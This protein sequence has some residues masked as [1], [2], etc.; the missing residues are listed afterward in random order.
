MKNRNKFV[1]KIKLG[2]R[3]RSMGLLKTTLLALAMV[4]FS[5]G[6]SAAGNSLS[7]DGTG[8]YVSF[9]EQDTFDL[10]GDFTIESWIYLNNTSSA[11]TI[12][13]KR[14]QGAANPNTN[15]SLRVD[16]GGQ[17]RFFWYNSTGALVDMSESGSSVTALSWQHIAATYDTSTNVAK[18]YVDGT[19]VSTKTA[20]SDPPTNN[21][22]FTIGASINAGNPA[23]FFNGYIDELR[24]S[25]TIRYS[26]SFTAPSLPFV[27]DSLT[28]AL[29]HFD[30]SAGLT[31]V[32]NF[33]SA[34]L[35]HDGVLQGN[36]T[37]STTAPS[38]SNWADN[39]MSFDG[40]DDFFD[41]GDNNNLDITGNLTVEAWVKAGAVTGITTITAKWDTA[42]VDERSYRLFL[43][44]GTPVFA[45][46]SNGTGETYVYSSSNVSTSTWNHIAGVYDGSNIYIFVNGTL[47]GTVAYSSGI[48]SG[49]ANFTVGA[50]NSDLY[51]TGDVDELR[52]SNS[53]RYTSSFTPPAENF[54][55][56]ANTA[57][58]VH[59]SHSDYQTV[60]IDASG[61]NLNLISNNGAAFISANYFDVSLSAGANNPG[62]TN[63]SSG[64]TDIPMLQFTIDASGAEEDISFTSVSVSASGTADDATDVTSVDLYR[65][66]NGNGLLDDGIDVFLASAAGYSSNDGDATISL[67][68]TISSGTSEDYLVAYSL[69]GTASN[70]ETFVAS[71][72]P[73]SITLTGVTSSGAYTANGTTVSGGVKTI[74]SS[75]YVTLSEGNDNP[76]NQNVNTSATDLVLLQMKVSATSASNVTVD[77]VLFLGTTGGSFDLNNISALNLYSDVNENGAFDSGVDTLISGPVIFRA[78]DYAGFR[79]LSHLVSAGT[80]QLW[81]VTADF[82]GETASNSIQ[83][84]LDA[85]ADFNIASGTVTGASVNGP[86]YTVSPTGSLNLTEGISNPGNTNEADDA[87]DV[88]VLQF[89]LSA[90]ATEAID[91]TRIEFSAS[92]TGNDAGDLTAYLYNDVND[93]GIYENGTDIQIGG[94]STYQTDDGITYWNLSLSAER[95]LAN[96]SKS[97]LLVYDFDGSAS[98][99]ETFR[100][101]ITNSGIEATGVTSTNSVT[102]LGSTVQGGI[103]TI[104]SS[105]S[106]TLS[107]NSLPAASNVA[108]NTANAA[109]YQFRLSA[110]STENIQV[111]SVTFE[112]IGTA[113]E[114][115]DI[116]SAG[117]NLYKDVNSNGQYD[118]GSDQFIGNGIR[119]GGSEISLDGSGD[120]L[121]LDVSQQYVGGNT[122]EGITIETWFRLDPSATNTEHIIASLD[123]S[124]FWR[125]SIATN[126]RPYFSTTNAAGTI[127]DLYGTTSLIANGTWYH[128][129]AVYEPSTGEKRIYI[130]GTLDASV[131]A[132]T[133]GT[134][135]GH[136]GVTRYPFIGT[137][138]EADTYDGTQGPTS[139]FHG[140]IDEFRIS[141][142]VRYTSDFTAPTTE[143]SPDANTVV[144]YH[145]N[146]GSG[147][148]INNASIAYYSVGDAELR[149]NSTFVQSTKISNSSIR[150]TTPNQ[151]IAAGGSVDWLLAYDVNS[152]P[153]NGETFRARITDLYGVDAS[154][155]SS[156][157]NIAPSASFPLNGNT[158]TVSNVGAIS[159]QVGSNTPSA[160]EIPNNTQSKAMLQMQVTAANIED[161]AIQSFTFKASGSGD[162]AADLDSVTVAKDL[163]DNGTYDDGVDE[164]ISTS[165]GTYA[166]NN[167]TTTINVVD[168]LTKNTSQNYLA[169]YYFDAT[170]TASDDETFSVEISTNT[171]I[172]ATGVTSST[173]PN[174]SGAPVTGQTMTINNAPK[175][176]LSP[177]SF[178]PGDENIS[179]TA[180]NVAMI[181]FN[182]AASQKETIKL[183]SIKFID[184]G[185][186]DVNT[187]LNTGDVRLYRDINNNGTLETGTD[188][189][190]GA[191]G[192]YIT[193]DPGNALSVDGT[194]DYA[195]FADD[196]NLDVTGA[197]TIEAW[198]YPSEGAT[199]TYTVLAKRDFGVEGTPTN[200]AL[201]VDNY[202][203]RFFFYSPDGSL[204]DCF[205]T[206]GDAIA[207]HTPIYP[208][209]WYHVAGVYDATDNEMRLYV[210]G[211]LVAQTT[212]ITNGPIPNDKPLDIGRRYNSGTPDSYFAGIIEEIRLSDTERYSGTSFTTP[213]T[214]FSTDANTRLL[215]HFDE[216]TGSTSIADSSGNGLTGTL[217]NGASIVTSNAPLFGG[218]TIPLSNKTITAGSSQNWLLVYDYNGNAIDADT[219][220]SRL[221]R[222]ADIT[223]VGNVSAAVADLSGLPVTG[224]KKTI[225][226]TGS[227]TVTEGTNNPAASSIANDAANVSMLQF[228]LSAS[229]VE[230]IDISSITFKA[231]GTGDDL[232][233]IKVNTIKLY[234]DENSDGLYSDGTDVFIGQG[235]SFSADNGTISISAAGFTL[236]ANTSSDYILIMSFDSTATPGETFSVQI[237][238]NVAI[239]ATG[240]TS[241]NSI[242]PPSVNFPIYG[243]N[244]TISDV[245][246]I[247]MSVGSNS[248]ANGDI[249][250]SSSTVEMMQIQLA[251]SSSENIK[252]GKLILKTNGT[253][254]DVTDLSEIYLYD[255]LNNNG[256][257]DTGVD[258]LITSNGG[259]FG[260][261]NGTL[262]FTFA[263]SIL[264]AASTTQ[265]WLVVYDFS[266]NGSNDDTFYPTIELSSYIGA[267]GVTSKLSVSVNG[268]F[269]LTGATKTIND[270]GS[271]TLG[272][273]PNSPAATNEAP[274]AVNVEMLQLSVG[275]SQTEA[276]A[277]DSLTLKA[278]G[279]I[280]DL[281][282]VVNVRLYK[283][284]NNNGALDLTIDTQLDT[285]RQFNANNGTVIFPTVNDTIAANGSENWLVIYDLDGNPSPGETFYVR[286]DVNANL[287]G[288]GETSAQA[289]SVSG[290]PINGNTKT[291]T[292]KGNL[293]LATGANNPGNSNETSDATNV[294]MIQFSLAASS[295]EN[296]K[297]N[298]LTFKHSGTLD[299]STDIATN[300][301]ELYEDDGDG[302]FND[303]N[304]IFVGSA[305]SYVNNGLDLDGTADY[306]ALRANS[307]SIG[308]TGSGGITVEA[309]VKL[310]ASAGTG[311]Y[312]LISLDRSDYWRLSIDNNKILWATAAIDGGTVIDDMY[313]GSNVSKGTWIHVAA[314][315]DPATGTKKI[316]YNGTLDGTSTPYSASTTLG[317]GS[318][319]YAFIGVG[320]EASSYNGPTGPV[321]YFFGEIDE[322]RIS[323]NVRYSSNFTPSSTPFIADANTSAL[324]QFDE[325]SGS[326]TKNVINGESNDFVGNTAFKSNTQIDPIYVTINTTGQVVPKSTTKKYLLIYDFTGTATNGETINASINKTFISA[327]GSTSGASISASG[328]QVTGGTK[329]ITNVGSISLSAGANNPDAS[330]E[331]ASTSNLVMMQLQLTT[332]SAETLAVSKF[333]VNGSGTADESTDITNLQLYRDEN[334]NGVFDSGVD[335]QI[336][337]SAT[338]SG[339]DGKATWNLSPADTL[340]AGTTTNWLVIYNLAGSASNG[341][342]IKASVQLA[343]NITVTGVES[344]QS[345][346]A[347]G[348]PVNGGVKT[349]TNIGQ[350]S[351]SL[352]TENPAANSYSVDAS[353]IVV[354][355]FSFDANSVEDIRID[356]LRFDPQGTLNHLAGITNARLYLDAV[357]NGQFDAVGDVLVADSSF[358][359]SLSTLTFAVGD[360]LLADQ[361][362]HYI[363]VYDLAGSASDSQTFRLNAASNNYFDATGLGG[364]DHAATVIGAPLTTNY[365]TLTAAGALDVVA[366]SANPGS[367]NEP[368]DA[369]GIAMLQ[370]RLTAS[371][372]ENINVTT[373]RINGVGTGDDAIDISQIG[374]YEDVNGNG[375]YDINTDQTIA[376]SSTFATND[377]YLTISTPGQV[378]TKG[379]SQN[380]LILY[381]FSGSASYGE[382][383]RTRLLEPGDVT[384]SGVTS[385]QS[386]TPTMSAIVGGLKTMSTTGNLTLAAGSSNPINGTINAGESGV[387]ILQLRLTASSAESLLVASAKFKASGT[388]NDQTDIS[389]VTLYNDLNDNGLF[390]SGV[391]TLLA[392]SGT[393]SADDTVITF[394]FADSVI[395]NAGETQNWLLAYDFNSG[396]SNNNTYKASIELASYINVTGAVSRQSLTPSGSFAVN[397]ATKSIVSVGILTINPGS[398]N[399]GDSYEAAGATNIEM[400]AINMSVSAAESLRVDQLTATAL[401]TINDV[402]DISS[403]RLYRD[404]NA[405][406]TLDL[407]VDTQL[408]T[409]HIYNGDN[410]TLVFA[411]NDTLIP[412]S[413]TDYLMVY[414]LSGSASADE[415]FNA[416]VDIGGYTVTGLESSQSATV[417]GE[418]ITSGK[419]TITSVGGLSLTAGTSNP[420]SSNEAN[421]ATD[422]EVLQFKL[423]A[424]SVENIN[425]SSVTFR[426]SGT[427]NPNTGITANHIDLYNDNGNGIYEP[428]TDVFVGNGTQYANYGLSFDGTGDYVALDAE[429]SS[430]GGGTSGGITIEAWFKLDASA[431]N[432]EHIIA[433]M[434]R[435]DYWRLSVY[436]N[437]QPYFSTASSTG[438]ID[439]L[440]GSTG[441]ISNGTWY[442]IAAV[443]DP[444]TGAK[445]IYINGQLDA[446]NSP[447]APSTNLGT[448]AD[449]YAFIGTG[450]ESPTFNGPTGPDEWFHGEID[451][452]RI[453][454]SVRYSSNFTPS[455]SPF[456]VDANTMAL[457]HMDES[458]GSTIKNSASSSGAGD[459]TLIGNTTFL[460][461]TTMDGNYI[462]IATSGQVVP[463][464]QSKTWLLVYDLAGTSTDGKTFIANIASSGIVAS[465]ATS[466]QNITATG[467]NVA[468]GT[469]TM[470]ST[471]SLTLSAGLNN[472]EPGTI[473]TDGSGIVMMQMQLQTSNN[474]PLEV[475][476]FKVKGS[477]TGIEN[478]DVDSVYLYRD[479]NSNGT[480]DTGVDTKLYNQGKVFSADNEVITWSFASPIVLSA[481]ATENWIVVYDYKGT[482]SNGETFQSRFELASYITATGQL[483]S[484]SITPS[485]P[486]PTPIT[487]NIQTISNIGNLQ[488]SLGTNNPS[489]SGFATDAQDV[490]VFQ[491]KISASSAEDIQV[492]TLKLDLQGT[493]TANTDISTARL[494][495]DDVQNGQLDLVGDVL[496]S[497][498]TIPASGPM[499]FIVEKIISA[500]TSKNYILVYNLA[501][502]A[503]I[504]EDFNIQITSNNYVKTT[505]QSGAA[506]QA[507]VLGAPILSNSMTITGNGTLFANVGP[508]NPGPSNEPN[509]AASLPMLQFTLSASNVENI[510][511]NSVT[512]SAQGTADD[513]NDIKA[514]G[515]KLYHDVNNNGI[516]DVG[517]DVF[518]NQGNAFSA[519][520]GS[521]TIATSG[522]TITKNSSENWLVLYDL[523]STA[524]NGETFIS[525]IVNPS[526]ISGV[527]VISGSTINPSKNGGGIEVVFG[528]PYTGRDISKTLPLVGGTKTISNVGSITLASGSSN[529]INS[530]VNND[531]AGIEMLQLQLSAS[532]SEDINISELKLK[533]SG[534][535][536]DQN[537][538]NSIKVYDD[539]NNNGIYDSGVDTLVA[540]P[541]SGY[542]ADNGT[543]TYS[544]G[545][546]RVIAGG[547]VENWLVVYDMGNTAT[548]GETFAISLQL[549]SYVTAAGATTT[550]S[551]TPGGTFPIN[552]ATKTIVS[553]GVLTISAGTNNPASG[554]EG[555]GGTNIVMLQA[556]FV[557]SAAEDLRIDS[558]VITGLGTFDPQTDVSSVK[559]YD[560]LNNNG[561]LDLT[562]DLQLDVGRTFDVSNQAKFYVDDTLN[563]G[564]TRNILVIYSLNGSAT[565]GETFQTKIDIGSAYVVGVPS[566]NVPN[567][568]GL[569]LTSNQM[570]IASSG[571]LTLS[572][573][574]NNPVD[575]FVSS[576][577]QDVAVT[578][579][580]LTASS[581]ENIAVNQVRFKH[582]GTADPDSLITANKIELYRDVNN[583]GSY[584]AGTDAFI[585]STSKY[586][587]GGVTFDGSTSNYIALDG[588]E[589]KLGGTTSSGITIEAFIYIDPSASNAEHIIASMD[590]SEYWRF[591]I[592]NYRLGFRTAATSGTQDALDGT[593]NL[594][595]GQWYHV[596]AVY[597]PS[598]GQKR[599]YVDG[600]LYTSSTPYAATTTLG[601]GSPTRYG[602]IGSG[603]EA[604]SHADVNRAPANTWYGQ[605]DEVR[606][607][608]SVRYTSNFAVPTTPFAADVN[609]VA[610]YHFEEISGTDL[611]DDAGNVPAEIRGSGITLT[612]ST[613]ISSLYASIITTGQVISASGNQNWLLIYDLAGRSPNGKTFSA[614]LFPTQIFAVG[615]TSSTSISAAGSSVSGGLKTLGSQGSVTLVQGSSN[616]SSGYIANG[617]SDKVMMQVKLTAAGD[618]ELAVTQFKIKASGTG[619]DQTGVTSVDLYV[620]TDDDGMLNVSTDRLL[621]AGSTFAA[622][623]STITFAVADTIAAG[624]YAN[625]LVIY[626]FATGLTNGKTYRATIEL[627]NYVLI[628]E[629]ATHVSRSVLGAP[630]YGNYQSVQNIGSINIALG[631]NNPGTIEEAN[632]ASNVVLSQIKLTTTAAET[633]SISQLVL[634]A[635]GTLDEST[636]VSAVKVYKDV[637]SNGVYDQSTDLLI[638]QNTSP[639]AG[640]NGQV[641]LTFSPNYSFPA[642]TTE[643]WLITYDLSGAAST[644]ETARISFSDNA[645]IAATGILTSQSAVVLGAPFNGN[646]LTVINVGALTLTAGLNNPGSTNET[647]SSLD[648]EMLQMY[649]AAS[650][651]ENIA[652]DSLIISA[653]GSGN[654][655]TALA[656]N[657]VRV[658]RDVNA[659]GV[660]E[661]GT[662]VLIGSAGNYSSDDG[663]FKLRTA[664]EVI[665]ASTSEY[666][667]VVYNFGG[668]AQNNQTFIAR[669]LEPTNVF[670]SG[671]TSGQPA[672]IS[673]DGIAQNKAGLLP[674]VTKNSDEA[675]KKASSPIVGGTKTISN[676]GSISLALGSNDPGPN[677]AAT[678]ESAFV[679]EQLRITAGNAEDVDISAI[680]F[681]GSGTLHETTDITNVQ[682]FDDVND[683]G[684]YDSGTD[685]QIGSNSTYSGDNGTVSFT[686][687]TQ[688]IASGTVEN[689]LLLYN[690]AG[691]GSNGETFKAS[692]TLTSHI[693]A[694]GASSGQGISP[695]GIPVVSGTHS[696]SSSGKLTLASG[697]HMPGASNEDLNATV[698]MYQLKMFANNVEDITMTQI[699]FTHSGTGDASEISAVK[700]FIDS[701]NDGVG[702]SQIGGDQTYSGSTVTF[703]SLAES[704]LLGDTNNYVVQYTFSAATNGTTFK[705]RLVNN[706]D[707]TITSGSGSAAAIGAP[708][709]GST[710]T[711]SST[712]SIN[713]AVG[714]NN[715]APQSYDRSSTNVTM[716][717]FDISPGAI[718][719][720]RM[721]GLIFTHQGDGDQ[722][723]DI[724]NNGVQLVRDNNND[725]NYDLGTDD[726][727]D[728]SNYSGTTVTFSL[729]DTVTASSTEHWFVMY[730]F[731]GNG[732][733]NSTFQTRLQSSSNVTATG[734]ISTN[735]MSV[736]GSF[737]LVGGSITITANASITVTGN[738]IGTGSINPGDTDVALLQLNLQ[739]DKNIGTITSIR[740]DN[741]SSF[742]TTSYSDVDLVK[743]YVEEGTTPGF[744]VLEDTE[745]GSGGLSDDGSGG[746]VTITLSPN[747]DVDNAGKT[748]YVTYD[749]NS[750]A[751]ST[752]NIGVRI[753]NDNY[754]TTANSQTLLNAGD[755]PINTTGDYS[756][757]VELTTFNAVAGEGVVLL[758]WSTGSEID[759]LGFAVERKS[760]DDGKYSEIASYVDNPELE[761]LGNSS[762]GANYS[763][764]DENVV[765]ENYTYRLIQYDR[766][767]ARNVVTT[768]WVVE[769]TELKPEAFSL[770]QNYPNPF[771]PQTSISFVLP[772]AQKVS[773]KIYNAIGQ[774]VVKLL[775]NEN[776][777]A[778]QNTMIWRGTDNS[779]RTVASGVYIYLIQ[780]DN[781]RALKKMIFMK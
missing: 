420:G 558:L 374:L 569:P 605:L 627:N 99:D 327:E 143:F 641:T 383:F 424:T 210:N 398:G 701:N 377:G 753:E 282:D 21:Y 545:S 607:S 579:F 315:Y 347:T 679:V 422:L 610:L 309:W 557:A 337:G 270:V 128:I 355:Q 646:Y 421:D 698:N 563:A 655:A 233:D 456:S 396:L 548:D 22:P 602:T 599:L 625:Y 754:I 263:D 11:H 166:S 517:T 756:L 685:T 60:A 182:L 213:S 584:D 303:Q 1:K 66:T 434:D 419:K 487:G 747:L 219:Y 294:E 458:S 292:A 331:S 69:A 759:N 321:S 257:Y 654:D 709:D 170:G 455:T 164:V 345:I 239:N 98:E 682:L 542:P 20:A 741:R 352:G 731:N 216:A 76:I 604:T 688:T 640:D 146:E 547:S 204:R 444:A 346:T 156:S 82:S 418:P 503:T 111:N 339:N 161:V 477:G 386:I 639:Y 574:A 568:V 450:S 121:P 488:I 670:A 12:L 402:T 678:D 226:N 699:V 721:T 254:S 518:I 61:N 53:A 662:D 343:S 231:N 486:F 401:G 328:S 643:N 460:G 387:E 265:H 404:N 757:P 760:H 555:S 293:T 59:A 308:G 529:P 73:N 527:G 735:T 341:E 748:L 541:T 457:Y 502:T 648:V 532:T 56:D 638:T 441:K 742:G 744:Q 214:A 752:N 535:G 304:D 619:N 663:S 388:G 633:L 132:Y 538:I 703:G 144:L 658:Y 193:G 575:G 115:T 260:S 722:V 642:S 726:I 375:I 449:R 725:G 223:A 142:T 496:I 465:G 777:P 446:S 765:L 611:S 608:N 448:G 435:S 242:T 730:D 500:G 70:S 224:G 702:D 594:N 676:V 227:I 49:A 167:G 708:I 229:D 136:T 228:N 137:G 14:N 649:I 673:L 141:N 469:K 710:K 436:T 149:D 577:A 169:V 312:I 615:Q 116:D 148:T 546:P 445:K 481:G 113:D 433:S 647:S 394:T 493:I 18:I 634:D 690:L 287:H 511:I 453:S 432:A 416:R 93:N 452:F 358:T 463:A 630:I 238:N 531:E 75:G 190:L 185:T 157:Q 45:V 728:Q 674:E 632:N 246:S 31:G 515:I 225:D 234:S 514:D 681:I 522:R 712:G 325:G 168:T 290:S 356:T 209:N 440:Y 252:I 94:S 667:L 524:S 138:S 645:N 24:I 42:S 425:I 89:T 431:T 572:V 498:A 732:T 332:A 80:N 51:L 405:N 526:D 746:T 181:Q 750:S 473:A 686:S 659:N 329:T 35:N 734:V 528:S 271:V 508:A 472:P 192:S 330:N 774:E 291:I 47:Y 719:D 171:G 349:I 81:L 370:F 454:N 550:Q 571:A 451:E 195:S 178:N 124:E 27:S 491:L 395:I 624:G 241:S 479:E 351:A 232:N 326:S 153:S 552:G 281:N 2:G 275:V 768:G 664:G 65:D 4:S 539:L 407:T 8:D 212:G 695:S 629:T 363:I 196:N 279:T 140:K 652:I 220:Q 623:D 507:N 155:E 38:L 724:S 637:N 588:D 262:T 5:Y 160:S 365:M 707:V 573:G 350:L 88:G 6:Q 736:N 44:N 562:S 470:T 771:N 123:R 609:T 384:A 523:D 199:S 595:T 775:N 537:D 79:D 459:G 264:L 285:T 617:E 183:T 206:G 596:A 751:T 57:L 288:V 172:G 570:T 427:A 510:N 342:T 19:V 117:I 770:N 198:V 7:L 109:I 147:T 601:T 338:F 133:A 439:D 334:D 622:N 691:T 636:D 361:S 176:T 693:T 657:G 749:I 684:I 414:D 598:T 277:I 429:Q 519:D 484:N 306:V 10:A 230:D 743:I 87:Q 62:V 302:I 251:A 533:S 83:L 755:Y 362:I 551:I 135:I 769:V 40:T 13:A 131:T 368:I 740:V 317:I 766:N 43:Q 39:A 248:P 635:S 154:G 525:R 413:Q 729:S 245:G 299:Q 653:A 29:F 107:F 201:R 194:N 267:K 367:S 186:G 737:P 592:I 372:V 41:V 462:T 566:L 207:T 475:S 108:I 256:T 103:K 464:G 97:F 403:V 559:L 490:S 119:Y 211:D 266:G 187:A 399:P 553:N 591:Y 578:Q 191:G 468:G 661:S 134:L 505:G 50:Q 717:Q 15:Y 392:A 540:G 217:Y 296:I 483:S 779:G 644:N 509:D 274:D 244:K 745:L 397:G 614:S 340:L 687:L 494:Y 259:P 139:Y 628:N 33:V 373:V 200:Y 606:I 64:G 612:T 316:Y 516:L 301:I 122:S 174:R 409:I 379:T 589:T 320:S 323:D 208:N 512:L 700:L 129:A 205:D 371:D 704:I 544:F 9:V 390:D 126:G 492:D 666:W 650:S 474:E 48:N 613:A 720:A 381:D 96:D 471:G 37:F 276:V 727:L 675:L 718:E 295:V 482:A 63:E 618:E 298:A 763:W 348:V 437:G 714:A 333:E 30:K 536:D 408:D 203:M 694:T 781:N 32:E 443:Y 353:G 485:G 250:K 110:S 366:G 284:V 677:T 616:P 476:Q 761:G 767:G 319:R 561:Q 354:G 660:Y 376:T 163:N 585:G 438:A 389:A 221:L 300:S 378:I 428:G 521:V 417:Q 391:D 716:L 705:V 501:G 237:Q 364:V 158:M 580:K 289:V 310:D 583:N 125:L 68:T 683:N 567:Y 357:K 91:V 393:F 55:T 114:T 780:T 151:T 307:S 67:S 58:L 84:S 180:Q 426:H 278:A 530:D 106:L 415:Y 297:V 150:I 495:S 17:I 359:D 597:E 669:I 706:G 593:T 249:L 268:S 556:K 253:G 430:I 72:D 3:M 410:G 286:F 489:A 16:A 23:N 255:D 78:T 90:N 586:R 442:H 560:D 713:M 52:V 423:N 739:A 626:D 696:I 197:L 773:L 152:A 564:A 581:V 656:N 400:L 461:N 671:V 344:S 466:G 322:L 173:T 478:T 776:R 336:G 104:K 680:K 162:D 758:S 269:P 738:D 159:M 311:E 513:V 467:N 243:K 692:M 272:K 382:T 85:N 102:T 689:W 369:S 215:V 504:G 36:A 120:Y 620:D 554:S 145:F 71:V 283:D 105:G 175:L 189:Y 25:K 222:P 95:I 184:I 697:D 480:F 506:H 411:L 764:S 772:K 305:A 360:T 26:G 412:G 92:G 313:G 101:E 520:N 499:T 273:G 715:P 762:I 240:A 733:N 603:S 534:T 179:N 202:N 324:Y 590:A 723:N 543:I 46:S 77:S 631:N 118:S 576:S 188:T 236:T 549:S 127:D 218:V 28:A 130:D 668:T 100:A 177:G 385:S 165:Y 261:D 34:D 247:T 665:A 447:Y 565:A 258:T 497:S 112:E 86:T 600:T 314:T 380:W 587:N 335:T 711:I 406:G 74:S 651:L 318:T 672:N 621:S 778:G 235:S 54:V 280:D 582:S